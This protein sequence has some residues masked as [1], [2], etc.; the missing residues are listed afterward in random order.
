MDGHFCTSCGTKLSSD[1]KFCNSCGSA[2]LSNSSTSEVSIDDLGPILGD[3]DSEISTKELIANNP[4]VTGAIFGLSALFIIIL[5]IVFNLPTREFQNSD[6]TSNSNPSVTNPPTS[7]GHWEKNCI[8][9][10]VPH[11]SIPGIDTFQ[12]QC[13]QVY[14]QDQ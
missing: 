12:D 7:T 1:W 13:D 6:T 10:R 8:K 11:P 14:V 2:A 4:Y 5:V 3:L 9:V